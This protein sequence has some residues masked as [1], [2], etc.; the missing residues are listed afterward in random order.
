MKL[1]NPAHGGILLP[2]LLVLF[3][4]LKLA[5]I[6]AWPWLWVLAPLWGPLAVAAVIVVAV[7]L[8]AFAA[9]SLRK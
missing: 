9:E 4:G 1:P 8:F 7:F 3:V 2:I 5:G 6:I